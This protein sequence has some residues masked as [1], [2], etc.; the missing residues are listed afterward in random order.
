MFNKHL[1]FALVILV[2]VLVAELAF[3]GVMHLEEQGISLRELTGQTEPTETQ[4]LQTL[5]PETEPPT[6]APTEATEP[7]TEPTETEPTEQRFLISFT[8]DCTLGSTPAK[9]YAANGFIQ[10][11]G[12][13]YGHPFRNTVQFFEQD[14]LT[15]A[16]LE[17]VIGDAGASV[18]KTFVFRGPAEYT[19]ILTL[20]SVEAVTLANNHAKDY[21][22]KGYEGTKGHLEE[23]GIAYVEDYSTLV[24]TTESGLTVGI[25]AAD[26]SVKAIKTDK[27]LSCIAELQDAGV[28]LIICAFHWGNEGEYRPTEAQQELGKAAI[29]AGAH[30]VWGNHPHVL[31]KIEEYN[32][33]IIYYSLGNFSFG[34]NSNPRDLD[35]AILQ[36]EVILY[37]DG[38]L[39]LGE[40]T[41]IPISISSAEKGN[42]FQPTPCEE[43]SEQYNRILSKL[44]GTFEG[45]DLNVDYSHLQ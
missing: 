30:I 1:K 23:A 31:Q 6:E 44:D 19:Q 37:S 27:V 10:T 8:G 38:T 32:G 40:L 39:E 3:V 2:I 20:G 34:G 4:P 7:E 36:Q 14:D 45:D 21:G 42:N 5:P 43:G 17:S 15:L 16:N 24:Y 26:G 25:C 33:G 28:D 18:G 29:D 9:S 22:T 11:I 13:D 41:I 12:E 35:S